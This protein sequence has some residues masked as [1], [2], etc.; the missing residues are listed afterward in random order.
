MAYE[1][2]PPDVLANYMHLLR[3]VLLEARFR[4]YGADPQLARLLDAVENLPDLLMRW[5]DLDEQ[6]IAEDLA[7]A[8]AAHPEWGRK[9]SRILEE[10]APAGWQLR[11]RE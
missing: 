4:T 2:P 7:A 6:I 5:S 10:G 11:R 8:E 1:L 9:F 3:S